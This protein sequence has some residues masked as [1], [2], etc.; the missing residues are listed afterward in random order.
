[1]KGSI[2]SKNI[3]YKIDCT[4]KKVSGIKVEGFNGESGMEIKLRNFIS[5]D[6]RTFPEIIE[7]SEKENK[8]EIRIRIKKIEFEDEERI[9]F[10]PG[11]NYEKI[12]IR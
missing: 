4:K 11:A 7:L 6:G 9:K 3:Y 10:I 5:L 8:S 12:L 2:N 1:M